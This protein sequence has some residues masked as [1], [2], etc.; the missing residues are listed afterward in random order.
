MRPRGEHQQPGTVPGRDAGGGQRPVQHGHRL[1]GPARQHAALRQCPVQVHQDIRL[2]GMLERAVGHLLGR[3]PVT[4]PVQGV[5]E[6][7]GQPA[8]LRRAGRGTRDRPA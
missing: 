7:A 6:P 3:R 5:G 4:H 1:R 2:G 8:V